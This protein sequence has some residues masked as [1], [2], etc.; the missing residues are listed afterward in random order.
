VLDAAG[1]AALAVHGVDG[2]ELP[3]SQAWN[4]DWSPAEVAIGV[5]GADE[6][7]RVRDRVRAFARNRLSA[8]P[9]DAYL[10]EVLA[11]ESD[12]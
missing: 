9:A 1:R 5:T 12:Y 4:L 2:G 10:A 11:A 7:Q 6:P 3:E 8:A